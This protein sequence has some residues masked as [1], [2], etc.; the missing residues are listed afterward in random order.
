MV[1]F[2]LAGA[3]VVM[4]ASALLRHG[5]AYVGELTRGLAAWLDRKGYSSVDEIRGLL[6]VRDGAHAGATARAG[7][8]AALQEAQGVYGSLAW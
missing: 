3:D 1:A 6:A 2:L 8:V 4:T 5:P 7:Y